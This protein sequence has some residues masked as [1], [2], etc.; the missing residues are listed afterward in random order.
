MIVCS[1]II[2]IKIKF[3]SRQ[4]V[5]NLHKSQIKRNRQLIT[6]L[7]VC[8]ILFFILISPILLLNVT[9]NVRDNSILSTI[10]YIF[11]YSNHA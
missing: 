8:N 10:A 3:K 5:G 2:I 4:L 7:F 6:V 1:F 9:G 11:A